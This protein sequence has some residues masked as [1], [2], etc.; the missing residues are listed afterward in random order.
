MVLDGIQGHVQSDSVTLKCGVPKD[1]S[2]DQFYLH[3]IYPPLGDISR[4]HGIDHHNYADDQQVYL[5]FSPTIDGDKE[6]CLNNLQNCIRNIRLW[7]RTNLLKLNDNKTEFIMVGSKNNLLKA[8]TRNTSVQIGNYFITCV[9]SVCDLGYIIDNEHTSMA[10]I[11]K[12]TSTLLITIRQIARI[13]HLIDKETTKI[14]M[15]ALVLSKLDYCNSL[16]IGMS[17]YNLDKLQRIQNMSCQVINNLKKYNSITSYL[18]DLQWLRICER[19]N[20]KILMMVF[21]CKMQASPNLS[22]GTDIF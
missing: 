2:L 14:L 21:R 20:Y 22:L 3:Y 15:Q 6:R 13:R 16:L 9:D 17:Q 5:S 19:I 7:M 18:Q 1:Q 8:N 10:H 11:N 4:N 12:L